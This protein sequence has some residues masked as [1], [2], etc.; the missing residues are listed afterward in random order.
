[1]SSPKHHTEILKNLSKE[2]EKIFQE[3][4][5]AIYAYLDDD[6]FI[7]NE[8]FATLLGYDSA[9][10]VENIRGDFLGTFVD[11]KSQQ[12]LASNYQKSMEKFE[13]SSLKVSWKKKNGSPLSTT[14]IMVPISYEGHLVALHFISS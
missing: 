14:C 3:S 13:A 12:D 8:K 7:C 1:M 11:G 5:Q 6:H 4:E 9:K 10:D 2:Y